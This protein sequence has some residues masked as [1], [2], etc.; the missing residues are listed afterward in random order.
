MTKDEFRTLY[1]RALDVAAQNAEAKL[2]CSVPRN[3]Q[4]E[5][6]GGAPSARTLS[7][8]EA[9]E[10]IYLGPD[11]FYRVID[12]S[13]CR[14]EHGLSIV[15]MVISGHRPGPLDQTWNQPPGNGPFKQV[16]ASEISTRP[17]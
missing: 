1:E 7:K 2:R 6:H 10:E 17:D 16:L 8:D 15:Y 14:V 4:I 12:L 9:F 11:S 3:F 5:L 13:V